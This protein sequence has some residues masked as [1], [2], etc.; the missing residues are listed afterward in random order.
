[1]IPD[2]GDHWS[3]VLDESA[4]LEELLATLPDDASLELF[5]LTNRNLAARMPFA[6]RRKLAIVD[7][8]RPILAAALERLER[9]DARLRHGQ[10]NVRGLLPRRVE[11]PPVPAP[12]PL[13]RDPDPT[14]PRAA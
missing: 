2:L 13:D 12:A 3:V 8:V 14:P 6:T 10:G 11:G 4:R 5:M 9:A 1:V 7:R